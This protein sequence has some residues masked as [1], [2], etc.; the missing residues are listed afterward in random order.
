VCYASKKQPVVATSS[1]EAERIAV[2]ELSKDVVWIRQA[3]GDF[4]FPQP[5]PRTIFEG[6][7]ACIAQSNDDTQ[8]SRSRHMD[9]KYHYARE[10]VAAG[11]IKLEY[12]NT[13]EMMADIL[14]KPLPRDQFIYLRDML[15]VTPNR[16]EQAWRSVSDTIR[17]AWSVHKQTMTRKDASMR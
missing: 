1:A 10:L 4:G 9:V 13:K 17:D 8:S 12:I 7:K 16:T 5:N 3:L 6:N 11:I 14:T 15:R 2:H